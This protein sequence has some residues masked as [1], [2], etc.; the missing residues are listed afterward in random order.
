MNR[1]ILFLGVLLILLVSPFCKGEDSETDEVDTV[2]QTS[3]YDKTFKFKNKLFSIPSPFHITDLILE[4]STVFNGD[5]VNPVENKSKYSTTDKKAL[6]LGIYTAD[7]GYANVFDQSVHTSKFIKVVRSL[8]SDLQ[9]MNVYT[10]EVLFKIEKNQQNKDSLNK[11][12]SEAYRET[13]I[14][15]TDNK[16][17]DVAVFIVIGAWTEGLYLMTQVSKEFSNEKLL[18][19]IGEQKY[20]LENIIKLLQQ[21]ENE[22]SANAEKLLRYLNDLKDSFKKVKIIYEYDKHIVMPNDHKTII[23]SKTHIE[24]DQETLNEIHEKVSELRSF[25]IS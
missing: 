23:L 7:L 17:G 13:D 9:I 18:N 16:R 21:Y 1:L 19:R 15:L 3:N 5:L 8:S 6:N 2:V 22:L 14:Y 11:I 25:I 4:T 12:F 10:E 24:L 20:S